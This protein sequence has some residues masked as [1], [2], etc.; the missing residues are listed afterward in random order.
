MEDEEDAKV[1]K[2]DRSLKYVR[3]E[4]GRKAIDLTEDD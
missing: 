1:I 2:S 3:I 4:G